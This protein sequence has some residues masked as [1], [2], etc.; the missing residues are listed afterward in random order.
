MLRAISAPVPLLSC[1]FIVA[2]GDGDVGDEPAFDTALLTGRGE[3]QVINLWD[4]ITGDCQR[5]G[6]QGMLT[7]G[8]LVGVTLV[9]KR[10]RP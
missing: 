6:I 8:T 5:E 9:R 1:A 2:C 10:L 7:S 3:V 4:S